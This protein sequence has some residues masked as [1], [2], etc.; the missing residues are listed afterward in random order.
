[1]LKTGY[2]T[3]KSKKRE[4]LRIISNC[5]KWGRLKKDHTIFRWKTR[6][7]H[8]IIRFFTPQT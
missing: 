3:N 2:T 5:L 1:M 4:K 6:I 8:R 7:Y